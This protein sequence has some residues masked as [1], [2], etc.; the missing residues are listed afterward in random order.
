MHGLGFGW[1]LGTRCAR[2]GAAHRP[3]TAHR[4]VLRRTGGCSSQQPRP[5]RRRPTRGRHRLERVKGMLGIGQ[6]RFLGTRCA[7]P[8]AAHRPRTVHWTVLERTGGCSSQQPRFKRRRVTHANNW[9]AVNCGFGRTWLRSAA[10]NAVR[11]WLKRYLEGRATLRS[12]QMLKS[13]SAFGH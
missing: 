8:G 9:T 7:R 5:K 13:A 1:S 2:P 4:T 6:G 10:A 11:S 12:G 3:R